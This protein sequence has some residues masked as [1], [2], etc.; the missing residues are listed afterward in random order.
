M[1]KQKRRQRRAARIATIV[2]LLLF[3][4]AVILLYRLGCT[5]WDNITGKA[6]GYSEPFQP[7]ASQTYNSDDGDIDLSMYPEQLV[8]LYNKNEDARQFVLDYFENKE[9][10]FDIDL[11]EY[12]NA[13]SVPLLMQWD[14][15]WGYSEYSGNLFGLSGCGPTCLSMVAI[16]LT[17]DTSMNPKWM[18]D[19]STENSYCT[20]KD[21]TEW[22]LI[23]EG[24]TKLGLDVTEIPLSEERIKANLDVGNPIICIMGPGD[25][26][27]SGHY[28][29]LTG[30]KDG[31]FT[32]NDP[33]SYI[34]SSL[35]WSYDDICDQIRNLWVLR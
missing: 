19:F 2:F 31:K 8:R 14:E 16:Y 21:G 7:N 22:A 15:R 18:A 9:K 6:S 17:G 11:S 5:I 27:D 4:L 23:S 28:I 35:T 30:M 3:A 34:N 13:D 24:G 1:Q 26:T 20:D 10:T 32:V 12:E 33:N 29:V 25:F